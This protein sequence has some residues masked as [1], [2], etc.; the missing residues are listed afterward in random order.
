MWKW[1]QFCFAW[2]FS[3][4]RLMV[5]V[6][7]LGAFLGLNMR[8]VGPNDCLLHIKGDLYDMYTAY[9]WGWPLPCIE[10]NTDDFGDFEV[11]CTHQTYYFLTIGPW[12]RTE[13]RHIYCGIIDGL[14]ALT[15]LSAILF[16]RDPRTRRS[17]TGPPVPAQRDEPPPDR[18]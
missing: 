13:N 6:L 9:R 15:V 10:E 2:R 5:G 17:C 1:L 7:F 18:E 11:P 16:L 4:T 12:L 14:F 3:L 8:M